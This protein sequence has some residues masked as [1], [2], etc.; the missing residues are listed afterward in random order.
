MAVQ[1]I[2]ILIITAYKRDPDFCRLF[3]LALTEKQIDADLSLAGLVWTGSA[4][5]RIQ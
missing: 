1:S 2:Q 5:H 3:D 4:E